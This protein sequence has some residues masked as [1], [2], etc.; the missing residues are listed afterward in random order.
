MNTTVGTRTG[1]SPDRRVPTI[2]DVAAMLRQSIAAG[3][4]A[5][6]TGADIDENALLLEVGVGLDSVML[7][8]LITDI[9]CRLG[10]EF[11]ESDLRTKSF[12]TV[13]T[14]MGFSDGEVGLYYSRK[15]YRKAISNLVAA[16]KLRFEVLPFDNHDLSARDDSAFALK[17]M[18]SDWTRKCWAS[19]AA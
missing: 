14:L 17:S 13:R 7:S 11:L 18:I 4:A 15:R 16:G 10:F 5:N 12:Q 9:E 19:G 3:P 8:E 2:D 6:L 1:E